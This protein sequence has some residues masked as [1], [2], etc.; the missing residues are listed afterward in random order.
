MTGKTV[1]ARF[2]PFSPP[3]A[4]P[5]L[6]DRARLRRSLTFTALFWILLAALSL[7]LVHTKQRDPKRAFQSIQINLASVQ[8]DS[9]KKTG[10]ASSAA[11]R[12][13][14]TKAAKLQSA[15]T[16]RVNRAGR[17]SGRA[18]PVRSS[19]LGIPDLAPSS[20]DRDRSDTVADFLEFGTTEST[21]DAGVPTRTGEKAAPAAIPEIEGTAATVQKNSGEPV[22][23]SSGAKAGDDDAPRVSAETTRALSDIA[24]SSVS[25]SAPQKE[26][27]GTG[28]AS[29]ARVSQNAQGEVLTAPI[30]GLSFEGTPRKALF[31]PP[32]VLPDNLARLVDASVSVTIAFTVLA[33]GSVPAAFVDFIPQAALPPAVRDYLVKEF[34]RWRF[35]KSDQDGHALFLYSIRIQ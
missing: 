11:E 8:S 3:S 26:S 31:S 18:E 24:R 34:S 9:A 27:H 2:S 1:F 12:P 15:A 14:E 25:G 30:A 32:I 19:G 17:A 4:D 29:D 20:R 23:S 35:E 6:N 7:L 5:D 13:L 33:D 28:K 10:S 21:P 22:R 16:P